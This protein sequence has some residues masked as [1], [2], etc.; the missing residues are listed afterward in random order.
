[1]TVTDSGT[2]SIRTTTSG[3]DGGYVVESLK[4][5]KYQITA[6]LDGFKE[7]TVTGISVQVAQRARV[8]VT[9]EI[10]GIMNTGSNLGGVLSPIVTPWIGERYGWE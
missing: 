9:L 8:D 10:G 4:P 7:T 1:M 6:G 5:D 3:A 2:G